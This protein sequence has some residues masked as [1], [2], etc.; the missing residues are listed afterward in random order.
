MGIES[1][2]VN[3]HQF[4]LVYLSKSSEGRHPVIFLHERKEFENEHTEQLYRGNEK[5]FV[6]SLASTVQ[7]TGKAV[8]VV[9]SPPSRHASDIQPYR[10]EIQSQFSAVDVTEHFAS[11]SKK[12]VLAT[13]D[14]S[15]A[16][17]EDD[18]QVTNQGAIRA[19]LRDAERICIVDDVYATGKTAT[20][21]I[22]KLDALASGPLDYIVACPLWVDDESPGA[23]EIR[24]S[25][26]LVKDKLPD[27]LKDVDILS[28]AAQDE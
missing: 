7:K 19:A 20:A 22:R 18:L 15:L 16:D 27:M 9:V 4:E 3:G 26:K 21:I 1:L 25:Q 5:L 23:K 28:G 14:S 13:G 24:K 6:S 17:I 12:Q 2:T 11:K 10:D 8:Q